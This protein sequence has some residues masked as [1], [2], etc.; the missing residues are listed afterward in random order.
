M[1]RGTVQRR[2]CRLEEEMRDLHA[3]WPIPALQVATLEEAQKILELLSML[4]RTKGPLMPK[5]SPEKTPELWALFEIL[6]ERL[7]TGLGEE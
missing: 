4:P 1:K 5:I 6:F 7:K 3:N 2:L